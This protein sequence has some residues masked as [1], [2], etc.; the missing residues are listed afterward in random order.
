MN[1][2]KFNNSS[3]QL[4]TINYIY[5]YT[6]K[7]LCKYGILSKYKGTILHWGAQ[8]LTNIGAWFDLLS[9]QVLTTVKEFILRNILSTSQY[10]VCHYL[11][12]KLWLSQSLRFQVLATFISHSKCRYFTV[13]LLLERELW[14]SQSL[15]L[16][17]S[18]LYLGLF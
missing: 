18:V 5:V 7:C 6:Y 15:R 9:A 11:G 1:Y 2:L 3:N 17:Q 14:P 8:G 4:N 12:R 10:T 16:Q 13:I